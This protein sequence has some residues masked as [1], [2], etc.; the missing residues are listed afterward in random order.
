[1]G[2]EDINMMYASS[3][4]GVIFEGGVEVGTEMSPSEDP[5]TR[6]RSS[7][8]SLIDLLPRQRKANW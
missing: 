7:D 3:D 2:P 1:M 8:D 4:P 6:R 5:L